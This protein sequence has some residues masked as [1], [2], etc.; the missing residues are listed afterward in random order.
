[1]EL[2]ELQ[3]ETV[4]VDGFVHLHLHSIYSALDGTCKPEDVAKKAKEFGMPAVAVTDHNHLGGTLEFQRACKK[5]GIKPILGFEAY[6][7]HNEKIASLP[8]E[9]RKLLAIC[10][11][12]KNEPEEKICLDITKTKKEHK[13]YR[14]YIKV[15]A[16][17]YHKDTDSDAVNFT[18]EKLKPE[19]ISNVFTKAMVA[20]FRKVNPEL[21][22]KYEYD[23]TQY[24]L[25]LL[26]MNQT[27][28][29]N[30][31]KIQSFAS[32][33]CTYNGRF[34]VDIDLLRQYSDGVICT[35]A[36]IGSMFSKYV[37]RKQLDKAERLVCIFKEIFGDRFYLELQPLCLPQQ[38]V[39]NEFY[40]SMHEKYDIPVVA[41]SDVHYINNEDHDDHDT[42][43]CI[44]MGR[45]KDESL[46]KQIWIKNHKKD[47]EGKGYRP[48]MKY[49]NEY[50]FR[51]KEEMAEAFLN[52]EDQSG[53]VYRKVANP[54]QTDEYRNL[55]IE[56]INTTVKVA[57]RVDDNILIGSKVPLYPITKNVPKGMTSDEWL[58]AEAVEGLV[59]YEKQ[60]EE[61]GTPID[62]DLYANKIIDEMAVISTKHYSDYFLGVQEYVNWANEINPETNLPNCVTGPG[63]G[64]AASSLVLFL[65]GVTKNVDPIKYN[66]MFSRF[67]TMDRNSPPD[68]KV[69]I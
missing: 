64:S 45:L 3:R 52:Q 51:S 42:F 63:R 40:M 35:T 2:K 65:I 66:L 4:T 50:W 21:I 54:L 20:A 41:T 59:K 68:W 17:E 58:M 24:H 47:P 53:N 6:M 5:V 37:Q 34:L 43:M 39:T 16:E 15:F 11:I 49:L 22:N 46:E 36:C 19:Y 48:R 62:H 31:L 23:M 33:R 57:E 28:W 30:L 13:E 1:M 18:I 14:E 25:I 8:I 67:L 60:M 26:A 9:E 56:A 10:D 44:A 38:M 55:W 27:G 12:F 69:A 61:A 7:T 29:N 32:E